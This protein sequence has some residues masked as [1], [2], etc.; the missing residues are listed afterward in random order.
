MGEFLGSGASLPCHPVFI[1]GAMQL[2]SAINDS[3]NRV[4]EKR[5]SIYMILL[6]SASFV[7]SP[8]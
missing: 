3:G 7:D 6:N 2:D 4:R 8:C 5:T 1:H